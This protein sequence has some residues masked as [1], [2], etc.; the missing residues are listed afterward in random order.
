M[1]INFITELN[2]REKQR[3]PQ[4][5]YIKTYYKRWPIYGVGNDRNK[6]IWM[7]MIDW[8]FV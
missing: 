7:K 3:V 2:Q 4:I 5:F 6:Y 1:K 8:L